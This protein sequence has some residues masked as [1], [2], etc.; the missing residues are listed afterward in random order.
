MERGTFSSDVMLDFLKGIKGKYQTGGI[1]ISKRLGRR[2]S[3]YIGFEPEL[4]SPPCFLEIDNDFALFCE[5]DTLL[6]K[7]WELIR[8]KLREMLYE[9][10]T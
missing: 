1:W 3:F 7:D 10:R 4:T 5:D 9:S 2:W 8:T 6:R